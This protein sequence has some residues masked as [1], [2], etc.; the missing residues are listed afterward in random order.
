MGG[1]VTAAPVRPLLL[2]VGGKGLV[3]IWKSSEKGLLLI[4]L[5]VYILV[6]LYFVFVFAA[7][8]L[9]MLLLVGGK[10]LVL[11]TNQRL[12]RAQKRVY[13]LLPNFFCHCS[14]HL[15]THIWCAAVTVPL[16]E[17]SSFLLLTADMKFQLQLR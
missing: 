15:V 4:C 2:L 16:V 10:G 12:G 13:C 3:T 5:Y 9:Q 7:P 1:G 8:V 11:P 14:L 17:A 6:F